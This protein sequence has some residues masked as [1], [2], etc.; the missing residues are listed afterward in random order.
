[1]P[2]VNKFSLCQHLYVTER[3]KRGLGRCSSVLM[4]SHHLHCKTENEA[5]FRRT[6]I[7]KKNWQG[8]EKASLKTVKEKD[9]SRRSSVLFCRGGKS[10]E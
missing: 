4:L 1:M 9:S 3:E 10:S 5:L 2:T 8:R 6:P 7:W